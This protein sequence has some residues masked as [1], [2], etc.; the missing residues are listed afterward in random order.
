MYYW[1]DSL[2][3]M[4]T[5]IVSLPFL[6]KSSVQESRETAQCRQ[7]CWQGRNY[8]VW[9]WVMRAERTN[10]PLDVFRIYEIDLPLRLPC[11]FERK[12]R[13][14][15]DPTPSE[16]TTGDPHFDQ[17]VEVTCDQPELWHWLAQNA[18]SRQALMA[19]LASYAVSSI[20]CDGTKLQLHTAQL[21][22]LPELPIEQLFH[23]VDAL[24]AMQLTHANTELR[25]PCS[26]LRF[27][28]GLLAVT[29][30]LLVDLYCSDGLFWQ[31]H[32]T[33]WTLFGY[34]LAGSGL[35]FAGSAIALQRWAGISVQ[36]QRLKRESLQVLWLTYPLLLCK[37]LVTVNM[38]QPAV[39]VVRIDSEVLWKYHQNN[40][41]NDSYRVELFQQGPVFGATPPLTWQIDSS[42]YQKVSE[43]QPVTLVIAQGHL[44]LPYVQSIAFLPTQQ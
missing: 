13:T 34:I 23:L 3:F 4:L 39:Q 9:E 36:K 16:Y 2:C 1:W 6:P 24:A 38:A 11:K 27:S 33:R 44:G 20:E 21:V 31:Q 17:K 12:A 41:G 19:L 30:G 25:N 22:Q 42:T 32:L 18:V 26:P 37:L 7:G 35:M 14:F 40:R 15:G 5:V 29:L 28:L 10:Q 8:L 43:K